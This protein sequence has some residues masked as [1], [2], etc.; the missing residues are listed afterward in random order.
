MRLPHPTSDSSLP[1]GLTEPQRRHVAVFLQQVEDALAEVELVAAG[2]ATGP[3]LLR[4]E[5]DDLPPGFE[6][7]VRQPMQRIRARLDA[8]IRAL[9]LES[10]FRSRS[11]HLQSLLLTTMVQVEDT[12]SRGLRGYG[13]IGPVV[14]DVV[15]RH[16]LRFIVIWR[17]W[18]P[19]SILRGRDEWNH[20]AFETSSRS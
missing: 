16:W 6:D 17:R 9:G 2:Q 14:Y 8:L 3:K 20:P 5:V 18:P 11:R 19:G 12:G 13:P 7:A 10:Q 15:D 4:Q 1:Q